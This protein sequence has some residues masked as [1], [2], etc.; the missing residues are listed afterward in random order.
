MPEN[1][2]IPESVK[3][4]FEVETDLLGKH[5]AEFE[6]IKKYGKRSAEAKE[7]SLM[8]RNR[9]VLY[10]KNLDL[11]KLEMIS[12]LKG[13]KL[14][15]LKDA[16]LKIAELE[17]GKSLT[18]EEQVA[19]MT[20]LD[21]QLN[22]EMKEEGL[23]IVVLRIED[24]Y[25]HFTQERTRIYQEV[26]AKERGWFGKLWEGYKNLPMPKKI[27]LS[28][29]ASGAIGAG[30]A[31][32]PVLWPA[33]FGVSPLVTYIGLGGFFGY[34]AARP[35]AGF[36]AAVGLRGLFA[37]W[38]E[39]RHGKQREQISKKVGGMI[40]DSERWLENRGHALQVMKE[41][42]DELKA[43]R[44]REQK[45]RKWPIIAGLIGGGA[46]VGLDWM[47]GPM[48]FGGGRGAPPA[49]KGEPMPAG[50][51]FD[52]GSMPG[53]AKPRGVPPAWRGSPL[54]GGPPFDDGSLPGAPR[55][56]PGGLHPSE[57]DVSGGRIA[58]VPGAPGA[59]V[60]STAPGGPGVTPPPPERIEY[61]SVGP[62]GEPGVSAEGPGATG[63]G[64]SPV[65][66]ESIPPPSGM[67][68]FP[69]GGAPGAGG[70]AAE[71]GAG[72]AA[73]AGTGG[74]PGMGAEPIPIGKHGPWGAL[75]DYFRAH[76]DIALQLGVD[77]SDAKSLNTGVGNLIEHIRN[78]QLDLPRFRGEMKG[79]GYLKG[80]ENLEY[81]PDDAANLKIWRSA[82]ETMMTKL[83]PGSNLYFELDANA[84]H[85]AN[86]YPSFEMMKNMKAAAGRFFEQAVSGRGGGGIAQEA[87]TPLGLPLEEA[88]G[89]GREILRVN[90]QT[91]VEKF[92]FSPA[93]YKSIENVNAFRFINNALSP[94]QVNSIREEGG[95]VTVDYGVRG[96]LG[97]ERLA[98][99][100]ALADAMRGNM[101]KL[102]LTWDVLDRMSVGQFV[103]MAGEKGL[104]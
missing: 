77:A 65:T 59:P 23:G 82:W 28:V 33:Y 5:R 31:A 36:G 15:D 60:P 25:R 96:Y 21:R 29:L 13:R 12:A 71:A 11:V 94:D 8:R 44:Q 2:E 22:R 99:D 48:G 86:V 42:D 34:R 18:P 103:R 40:Q 1:Y 47:Y 16:A 55:V 63:T 24:V 78:E 102:G 26:H 80:M 85:G 64:I 57:Y 95:L 104:R 49:W 45:W 91:V 76:K 46:I 51:P 39:R 87:T 6:A 56:Y 52:E 30:I 14:N 84:P 89:L 41:L 38:G 75:R 50:P 72:T 67:Y 53:V 79:L 10:E 32:A 98:K 58:P 68:P 35:I 69:E 93:E 97:A 17:K 70:A 43:V 90:E 20:K 83:K 61:A 92:K 101:K 66:A 74:F 54:P 81:N 88:R 100:T 62:E 37:R 19:V 4:F 73:E 27:A 3:H 7:A 9:E